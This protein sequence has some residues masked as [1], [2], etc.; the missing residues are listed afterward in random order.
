[1]LPRRKLGE[2]LLVRGLITNEQLKKGLEKQE[3]DGGRIGSVLVG[4]GY[5]A[6]DELLRF[7]SLAYDVPQ[8]D[9]RKT[10]EQPAA[11]ERLPA[12]LARETM[13]VP[14]KIV[15]RPPDE[16]AMIVATPDPTD[17]DSMEILK[18]ATGCF[19]EP[20]VCSHGMFEVFFQEVYRD[21]E[22]PD[23]LRMILSCYSDQ[24]VLFALLRTLID[25]K[26]ISLAD[27][28]AALRAEFGDKEN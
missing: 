3:A 8:I 17:W 4:L 24:N 9:L 26:V 28:R 14:V 25:K 15:E 21:C 20:Y 6:E 7:L 10:E 12:R 27:L 23:S 13:V 2:M 16:P 1:M 18:Q 22:A 19:V 11:A 5:L